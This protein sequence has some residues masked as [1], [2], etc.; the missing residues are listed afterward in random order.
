MMKRHVP[1][2]IILSL[3]RFATMGWTIDLGEEIILVSSPSDLKFSLNTSGSMGIDSRGRTHLVY[4]IP[5]ESSQPPQNQIFYQSIRDA[6]SSTPLRIDN[7]EFGGGRHP[8]LAVD[9]H[10][11]V[12]VVWQDYRHTTASGNYIDNLEIYYDKK[13][14]SGSF[15]P[16]DIRITKTSATHQGD[17]GYV[18]NIALFQNDRVAIAWYD[19]TQ[20]GNNADVY[21]RTSDEVGDFPPVEGI[22]EFRITTSIEDGTQ[23]TSNWMPD[24]CSLQNGSLYI[25]WGFLQGWQ[26]VF[27]LNGQEI[28]ADGTFGEIETIADKNGRFLDPPRI[29]SD[30]HG[31]VGLVSSESIGGIYR[32]NFL[33]KPRGGTWQNPVHVNDGNLSASQPAIAF[34]SQGT[35]YVVWQEDLSG[36]DQSLLARIDPQNQSVTERILL[37]REDRD[38][39]TPTIS[40]DPQ[41][42]RIHVAWIEDGWDDTHSIVYRQEKATAVS[43][44]QW[45]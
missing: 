7:G 45:N 26:G 3:I 17:S 5:D 32:I 12:H 27:Q 24:V 6:T 33:Y 4:F 11:T 1:I 36:M 15:S 37:N 35:A 10:D 23:Y 9:S 40:I 44:W 21:L 22:E 30:S 34:D 25:V 18:P 16:E 38:A 42:D 19:F 31:N 20:N 41:T 29:V 13:T 14:A 8:T 28:F 43:G 2:L 39:H